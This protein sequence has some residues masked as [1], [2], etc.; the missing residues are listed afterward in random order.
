M[1]S[2][3][4][5]GLQVAEEGDIPIGRATIMEIGAGCRLRIINH[6]G[7]QV[8]DTWVFVAGSN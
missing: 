3:L 5:A 2:I 7:Q 4:A 6:L 1:E 8:V